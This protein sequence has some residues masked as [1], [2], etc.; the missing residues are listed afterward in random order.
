MLRIRTLFKFSGLISSL[1]ERSILPRRFHDEFTSPEPLIPAKKP[2]KPVQQKPIPTAVAGKY[3]AFRDADATV[4]LDVDE[5]RQRL[6]DTL[7]EAEIAEE[8]AHDDDETAESAS[9]IYAGLNL[10]RKL[11]TR[12][13]SC[14]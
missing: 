7:L 11:Y 1:P 4:I 14:D 10:E 6:Q 9:S 2:L 8:N 3:Q 5:E 13:G 12:V